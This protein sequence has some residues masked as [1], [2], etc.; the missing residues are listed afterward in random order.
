MVHHAPTTWTNRWDPPHHRSFTCHTH[1]SPQ[2][3]A[4]C[5]ALNRY[6]LFAWEGQT[7]GK[8]YTQRAWIQVST[9]TFGSCESWRSWS[10]VQGS[11]SFHTCHLILNSVLL[12]ATDDWA[13][14]KL[15]ADEWPRRQQAVSQCWKW[16]PSES[17]LL[18]WLFES[19]LFIH[20]LCGLRQVPQLSSL[21]PKQA[22][23][24]LTFHL[25]C[26]IIGSII[27]IRKFSCMCIIAHYF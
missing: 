16:V 8:A 26:K 7:T 5:L 11:P 1:C 10:D 20:Q 17:R 23:Y 3:P 12:K 2:G 14:Q 6:M 13:R 18:I 25:A 22:C 15:W 21:S 24:V 9:L 4:W 19:Q 27:F